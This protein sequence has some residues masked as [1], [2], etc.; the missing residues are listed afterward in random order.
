MGY[1]VFENKEEIDVRSI[2]TFGVSVKETENPIGYF[3][4]GLKYALSIL[5]R[6]GHEVIILSGVQTFQFGLKEV[7]IRGK[8]FEVVTMNDEELPFTTELGK[9]WEVWQAFRE[10]YCNCIDEKGIAESTW[11]MPNP[12]AGVTKV[13]V[14]GDEFKR[15][16]DKR[17]EIVLEIDPQTKIIDREVQVFNKASKYLYYRGVR[18]M[19]LEDEALFTYN[20]VDSL[21]LTEDRTVK[22]EHTATSKLPR[23][24][25]SLKDKELIRRVL[26]APRDAFESNLNFDQLTY[27]ADSVSDEFKEVL[28]YEYNL[29]ND[30][31]SRTAVEYHKHIMN[32]K[33]SK[34][35]VEISMNSVELR[36]LE[37]VR[38]ICRTLYAD[39]DLYK[40]MV[41][42]S[43]GQ[44]THAVADSDNRRM[45][46]AKVC[47]ERG[48][49]YLLSTVIEEYAHLTTGYGD[50]TRE[51]QT[52]LFDNI[53][54]IVEN[55]VLK[56]PI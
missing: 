11:L 45:V 7:T 1:V 31:L 3:G 15:I 56:E 10:I 13:I 26:L 14:K 29:N 19:E 24:L 5:L 47:F 32:K 38:S 33:A 55:H 46:I 49:K 28:E 35:Y 18:V 39:F 51:L 44:N 36:Q 16:F 8:K 50:R 2:S 41:V 17:K 40:I 53:C 22:Y 54:T 9:N 37:K 23:V 20:V 42:Q 4:T 12:K 21:E 34:N 6:T 30:R 25:A 52:W 43:L 48:T 27:W